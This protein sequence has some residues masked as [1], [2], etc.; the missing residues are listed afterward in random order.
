[1]ADG[2]DTRHTPGKKPPCDTFPLKIP[3]EEV[4]FWLKVN[5]TKL[6]HSV[7]YADGF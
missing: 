5:K 1:M 6:I 3:P 7:L 4:N 2:K